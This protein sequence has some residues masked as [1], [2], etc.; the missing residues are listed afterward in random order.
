MKITTVNFKAELDIEKNVRAIQ[1]I[2]R[3]HAE[4]DIVVFP[5]ASLQGYRPFLE[6][7]SILYYL[8]TAIDLSKKHNVIKV[9][10][11]TADKNN[12]TIIVGG[13]ERD[14]SEGYGRMY[15][16]AFIFRPQK[17]VQ[18]YRK[19]HL[20]ANEPYFLF[21]GDSLDV[22]DTSV[23]KVGILICYDKCFCEAARTL[24]IKGA[25]IIVVISAWAYSS[26]DQSDD[27][28]KDDHSRAVFDVYDQVRAVE[29]QCM[30]VVANQV[31]V[32]DDR[33]LEFLGR[34]KV[35]APSGKI[36]GELGDESEELSLDID[37]PQLMIEERVLNLSAL[38]ILRNR[39]P[40]IYFD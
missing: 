27:L 21:A 10:Q 6:S 35:V 11:E 29:N 32:S 18:T 40:S 1:R 19:T 3:E 33:S 8:N 4:S 14:D 16:T 31:G 38:N 24:A 36:L 5:E 28:K 15:D 39:R 26:V 7:E 34:S 2:L 13:I 9:L 25:E 17:S 20:A 37:L 30:I 23:G 22:F 12:Q